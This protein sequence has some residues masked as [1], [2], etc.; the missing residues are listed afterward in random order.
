M[1][2][3]FDPLKP[4]TLALQVEWFED[5]QSWQTEMF[6]SELVSR[7]DAL[8]EN[9]D[10]VIARLGGRLVS[11]VKGVTRGAAAARFND[12]AQL[13][14]EIQAL[15]DRMKSETDLKIR[16]SFSAQLRERPTLMQ[17]LVDFVA[18]LEAVT[19]DIE[20]PDADAEEED[21]APRATRQER[22]IAF[23][24]YT[25]A[26]RAHAR[27]VAAR[28]ALSRQSRNGKII[29]WLGER[30]L[31][32]DELRTV[33]SSLQTQASLRRFLNPMRRYVMALPLRYRRY[34]RD[35]QAE[36]RWY[37]ETSFAP[38]D[39]SPLEVDLVLLAILRT[40]R[41]LLGDRRIANAVSEPRNAFLGTV[42]G[43]F[44]N[45][46]AVDEATDFSPLQLACMAGLCDPATNSFLACGDFNQR[47]TAWG[48]RSTDDLRWVFPNMD[49]RPI[50]ISYRHSRQLNDL[51]G[52][53]AVAGGAPVPDVQLPP[54]T[55][56]EGV[57]AIL[58]TGMS[59]PGDVVAWLA[60]RIAEIERFTG[61]MPS[62]AI[63][64]N[65]EDD[66]VPTAEAVDAALAEG[67]VRCVACSGG[68]SVGQENDVR[69][70][71]VEHIKGLE[72]EAVFFISVDVLA[73]RLPDLF[74]KYLY[75]GATR[76]AYFLGL[77]TSEAHLPGKLEA[78]EPLLASDWR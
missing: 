61:S 44:R 32:T 53:I 56:N 48:S 38:S 3:A 74:D 24:A 20:D 22:E 75:V 10:P 5:F 4:E 77:T 47:I 66:V 68:H 23:E 34:R 14:E 72:F 49:I 13:G 41:E 46:I 59:T 51:A 42:R 50:N 39:L 78:I 35:R 57:P 63:L 60:A 15:V 8:A 31:A 65:D 58:A 12:M 27:A 40:A 17:E 28:R 2:E 64:V 19:D 55:N 73:A 43:L 76:A 1:K 54:D 29:E 21:E 9:A 62:I 71:A 30:L 33:G 70:F 36:G 67:N 11:L 52:R 26:I 25:R 7:A 45:Q 37:L 16:G 6:W 69:V 18:T